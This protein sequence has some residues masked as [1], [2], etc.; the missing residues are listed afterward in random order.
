[1]LSVRLGNGSLTSPKNYS[2]LWSDSD[3][4]EHPLQQVSEKTFTA[5]EVDSVS[6]RGLSLSRLFSIA[7]GLFYHIPWKSEKFCIWGLTKIWIFSIRVWYMILCKK[8]KTN[9][10]HTGRG[11]TPYLMRLLLCYFS[12]VCYYIF[13][14]LL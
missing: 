7:I 14:N 2:G 9:S 10:E 6:N 4:Q 3:L 1:M 5:R 11:I 12:H 8:N 13:R